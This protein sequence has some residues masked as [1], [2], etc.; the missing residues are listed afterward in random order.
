LGVR[1]F[2]SNR[3]GALHTETRATNLNLNRRVGIERVA[4]AKAKRRLK[5][6]S[7][8]NARIDWIGAR[9]ANDTAGSDVARHHK[10]IGRRDA[11]IDRVGARPA[12][13][14]VLRCH[15]EN[16]DSVFWKGGAL[17]D[18]VMDWCATV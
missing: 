1:R 2:L 5:V 16:H 4:S 9:A 17:G 8:R 12:N 11:W 13:N 14:A 18:C 15:V 6:V 3:S 10:V 7:R